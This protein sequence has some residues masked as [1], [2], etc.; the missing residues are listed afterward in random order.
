MG[1][2]FTKLST[3][4]KNVWIISKCKL[5]LLQAFYIKHILEIFLKNV[6][7]ILVTLHNIR[8]EIVTILQCLLY[9]YNFLHLLFLN[10]K[11][12]YTQI[13]ININCNALYIIQY[14]VIEN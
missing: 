5:I 3:F 13:C 7:N 14:S 6:C 12:I 9:C 8:K 4:Y 1:E 2:L 10:Y 11:R